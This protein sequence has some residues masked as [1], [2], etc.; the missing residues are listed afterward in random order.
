MRKA[1]QRRLECGGRHAHGEIEGGAEEEVSLP[2]SKASSYLNLYTIRTLF[3]KN[4][5]I[6]QQ[7][8]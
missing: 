7:L 5:L 4:H 3:L 2:Y 6:E 1:R 8:E